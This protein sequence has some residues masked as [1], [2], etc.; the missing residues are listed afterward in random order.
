M[1]TD[2]SLSRFI[3]VNRYDDCYIIFCKCVQIKSIVVQYI[4]FINGEICKSK[5]VKGRHSLTLQKRCFVLNFIYL[6]YLASFL[7]YL[8]TLLT[9]LTQVCFS[10][11]L[12]LKQTIL[13]KG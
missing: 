1:Y 6:T 3:V 10:K 9:Q 7:A 2:T 12:T 8:L 13:F 5:F 4:Y 11:L